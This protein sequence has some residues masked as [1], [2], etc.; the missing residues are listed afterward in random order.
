MNDDILLIIILVVGAVFV[1]GSFF[2][3]ILLFKYKSGQYQK[4]KAAEN[5]HPGTR[6]R[7]ADTAPKTDE[8]PVESGQEP[9]DSKYRFSLKN[10]SPSSAVALISLVIAL[11]F[12]PQLPEDLA[13]RFT[14]HGEPV[15]WASAN[16]VILVS[17]VLQ[18]IFLGLGWLTGKLVFK[19]LLATS[20]SAATFKKGLNLAILCSNMV[21]L[22]QV[23][24]A[25][26][27][28]DIFS[29]NVSGVHLMPA[30]LFIIIAMVAGGIIIAFYFAK[31]MRLE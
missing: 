13:F 14:S 18:A 1:F 22:P 12:L 19:M 8:S 30:W 21:A 20:P 11:V 3:L 29:Y 24:L 10:M 6:R 26:L 9:V 2:G 16:A 27:A 25:F 15:N 4:T 28:A 31:I 5:S 17:L 23:I 7:D